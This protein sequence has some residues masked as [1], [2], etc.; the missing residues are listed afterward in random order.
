MLFLE[1]LRTLAFWLIVLILTLNFLFLVFVL[2]RRLARQRYFAERDA[3]REQ[4][5]EVIDE[6]VYRGASLEQTAELLIPAKSNAERSAIQELLFK[7]LTSETS[8]NISQLMFA[9]GFVDDWAEAA[10]GKK[11]GAELVR[12]SLTR[13]AA[14]PA[15]RP[16]NPLVRWFLGIRMFA[17]PRAIA[18]DSLGKLAPKHAH[19]FL[20]TALRDSSSTVRRVTI[21]NMG[22]NRFPEAIPLLVEELES[23]LAQR[24]D[25]S[26]R[27]MK[28]A[29]VSYELEDLELF[30]PFLYRPHRRAR[31]F[32]I[33]TIRE[34]CNRASRSKLLTKNDFSPALC[35]AVQEQCVSDEFEDVRARCSYVVRHFRDANA[36][37]SLRKLINDP[38]EFVRMHAVRACANRFYADLVSDVVPRLFDTRWIVREAAVST[39]GAMG[40]RGR[41]EMYRIFADCSDQFASEQIAEELQRE[42]MVPDL[43]ANV[44]QGGGAALLAQSVIRKLVALEKTTILLMQME[45]VESPEAK[46]FLMDTLAGNPTD[47]YIAILHTISYSSS[48]NVRTKS[49]Q[50]LR[51]L[52]VAVEGFSSDSGTSSP[53]GSAPPSGSRPAGPGSGSSQSR[54]SG[55]TAPKP[56]SSGGNE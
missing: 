24:N 42:G 31:F 5:R 34:I 53:S 36:I 10:F 1:D 20:A 8:V 49:R 52:G 41:E 46:A 6:F 17:V 29:L 51:K 30:V 32:V 45:T 28:A 18:V 19:V 33:D 9:L 22:R 35:Q 7:N 55:S 2:H 3:A 25:V 38:N 56:T 39:L 13:E 14:I 50:I 48:G 44:A 4:Y 15:R 40:P 16:L 21:E 47:A 11:L 26:L 54:P 27:S 12:Q 23:A 43:V 37:E